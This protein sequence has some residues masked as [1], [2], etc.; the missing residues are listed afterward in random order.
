MIKGSTEDTRSSVFT[1]RFTRNVLVK[2]VFLFI[3][4]NLIFL[5][6]DPLPS[7]SRISGYNRIF[8]GRY[9]LPFGEDLERSYNISILDPEAMLQSH[10]IHDR[11]KAADEFRIVLIGDSSVW[12]FNLTPEQTLSAT[13]NR[14]NLRTSSGA[15]VQVFNLG[16]P[17]MSITKDLLLLDLSLR[18]DPDLI[19]WFVTLESM[20]LEKQLTSPLV[21]YN[22]EMIG[23]LIRSHSLGL[24]PQ[25]EAFIVPTL[26]GRTIVGQRQ[27]LADWVRLQLLG[28]LWSATGVD[29]DVPEAYSHPDE[30]VDPEL[31]FQGFEPGELTQDDLSLEVIKAGIRAAGNVPVMLINEPIFI[32][33]GENSDLR[34]NS[35]YPRWVYDEYR[36]ILAESAREG[37]WDYVDLWDTVPA[38]EFTDSAIHYSPGGVRTVADQIIKALNLEPMGPP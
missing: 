13:M 15:S 14:E 27:E 30:D 38:D 37:G 22:P 23:E 34:Y 20:P 10:V 12:G 28:F 35:F 2:T 8:P 26:L 6:L 25:D 21:Q 7:L 19:I 11:P 29:H 36:N 18:F 4:F 31:N 3:L 17:T 9:R 5:W 1:R 32:A 16:Y 33:R 24:D